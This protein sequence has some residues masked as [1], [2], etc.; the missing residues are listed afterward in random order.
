MFNQ[1]CYAAW[2]EA[3]FR[4]LTKGWP[5]SRSWVGQNPAIL[6]QFKVRS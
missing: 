3:T 6:A 5:I 1:L 4:R 2:L